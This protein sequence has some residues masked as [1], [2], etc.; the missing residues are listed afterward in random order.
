MF[1]Q[2]WPMEYLINIKDVNIR[3]VYNVRKDKIT[4]MRL[5]SKVLAYYLKIL[6]RTCH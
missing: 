3:G 2:P 4:K 5:K 6:D 1:A